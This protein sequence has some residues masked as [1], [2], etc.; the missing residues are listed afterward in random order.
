M[1]ITQPFLTNFDGSFDANFSFVIFLV[2]FGGKMGV[3]VD[4]TNKFAISIPG[5]DLQN[6]F[7][8]KTSNFE[9]SNPC[10]MAAS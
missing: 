1:V 8:Y 2:G 6:K 4:R 10:F 9:S 5:V 7:E 3:G